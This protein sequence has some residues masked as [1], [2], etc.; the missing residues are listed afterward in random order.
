[1]ESTGVPGR[2]Q[3]TSQVRD[4]LANDFD[5]EERGTVTVKGKDDQHTWFLLDRRTEP[6]I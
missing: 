3:V 6:A 2:I 5:F 1:M 4:E